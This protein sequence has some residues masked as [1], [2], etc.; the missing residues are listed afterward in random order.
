MGHL[1]RF[2]YSQTIATLEATIATHDSAAAT[3]QDERR[4]LQQQIDDLQ[5]SVQRLEARSVSSM[6]QQSSAPQDTHPPESS[7]RASGLFPPALDTTEPPVVA[8]D[9]AIRATEPGPIRSSTSYSV[10]RQQQQEDAEIV[11]VLSSGGVQTH[12]DYFL[13]TATHPNAPSPFSPTAMPSTTTGVVTMS[14][15]GPSAMSTS[16]ST[17][18]GFVL[19]DELQQQVHA[20]QRL[21][22]QRSVE[23]DESQMHLRREREEKEKLSQRCEELAAFLSRARKITSGGSVIGATG[24]GTGSSEAAGQGVGAAGASPAVNLDYLKQVVYKFVTAAEHSERQRLLPVLCALLSFTA[25]EKAQAVAC[26]DQWQSSVDSVLGMT[27]SN[28]EVISS[29]FSWLGGLT[30]DSTTSSSSSS[31]SRK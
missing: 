26:L 17:A 2:I 29:A 10:Q 25:K 19:V 7:S 21:V 24:A 16:T 8:I 18:S 30:G 13:S 27:A 5:A 1:S 14:A 20:L 22:A 3:W 15:A 31:G 9:T 28:V 23:V 4:Q 11:R 6:A 12:D